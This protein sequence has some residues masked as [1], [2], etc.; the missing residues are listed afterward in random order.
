MT[1]QP[2]LR[3]EAGGV[4]TLTL[5]R[6]EKLNALSRAIFLELR[7]NL[8]EIA[9]DQ[10]VRC[11]VLTG[12]G[13]SFCA[14]NDLGGL[15]ERDESYSSS[16]EA[17]TIDLLEALPQPTIAKINGYCFTGG[18][19]L[20]L[21]CDLLIAG[22]SAILGDTHGQWGLVPLWGMSIRLPLR[23]GYA[24]AKELMFTS[25]RITGSQAASI[26]LVNHCVP[27][28][29]LNEKVSEL[30][31]EIVANSWGTNQIVKRLLA[32]SQ[33]LA[34]REALQRERTAPYGQPADR[35]ERMRL[36]P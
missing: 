21:A 20:A 7:R 24:V 9:S 2:L 23:V 19:E 32:D 11:L 10:R 26:G 25:R 1:N 15:R 6:P 14:G 28:A 8:E 29:T 5:N 36:A 35:S 16:F 30:A 13:R 17:E 33:E 27:D 22:E 18:L 12:A 3:S 34:P 4:V 31:D